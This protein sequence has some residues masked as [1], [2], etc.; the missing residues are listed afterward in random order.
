M[1]LAIAVE[2]DVR[3]ARMG[4]GDIGHRRHLRSGKD[5]TLMVPAFAGL[6]SPR[7]APLSAAPD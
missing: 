3:Q 5:V 6:E 4:S 2:R 7:P 1:P